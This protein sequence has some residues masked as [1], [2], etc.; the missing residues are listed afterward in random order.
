MKERKFHWKCQEFHQ[1]FYPKGE[2]ILSSSH[3]NNAE[4]RVRKYN[5]ILRTINPQP[6]TPQWNDWYQIDFVVMAFRIDWLLK[7]RSIGQ[8]TELYI[9]LNEWFRQ[10][11]FGTNYH[12]GDYLPKSHIQF[13]V[14][15]S[16]VPKLNVW[17]SALRNSSTGARRLSLFNCVSIQVTWNILNFNNF[18]YSLSKKN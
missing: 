6:H 11:R 17:R 5:L 1:V 9:E 18:I 15:S 8:S 10:N 2:F 7:N 3:G 12:S 14:S 16:T 13:I 4:K